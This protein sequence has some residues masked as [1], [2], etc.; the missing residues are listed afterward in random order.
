[1]PPLARVVQEDGKLLIQAVLE[2]GST[3]FNIYRNVLS[4]PQ[5]CNYLFCCTSNIFSSLIVI[6]FLLS[7]FS[8]ALSRASGAGHLGA[9]WSSLQKCFSVWTSIV[10]LC[11]LCGWRR[12]CSLP[13]SRHR[14]S[15]LNRK[16][17][18]HI[19]YSGNTSWLK[20]PTTWPVTWFSTFMLYNC[21]YLC[22]L[23]HAENEWTRGGW[24]T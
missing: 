1:M 9:W 19:R 20:S 15:Q 24:R 13:G 6:K 3:T 18:S 10:F 16:T 2:V 21:M 8:P 22:L 17:T 12:R 14:G 11:S 7:Y 5:C 4:F 23:C